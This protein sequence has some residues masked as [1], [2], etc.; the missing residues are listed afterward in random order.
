MDKYIYKNNMFYMRINEMYIYVANQ[1]VIVE[2]QEMY[3]RYTH[4][5]NPMSDYGHAM[6][7]ANRGRVEGG[8]YGEYEHHYDGTDGVRI[9]DLYD[10]IREAWADEATRP[11][12]A[13]YASLTAEQVCACFT[14]EDIVDG[15]DGFDS[16][17][18]LTW[19][20]EQVCEPEGIMALLT[21]DGAI[22]F[23]RALIETQEV[24]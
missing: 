3:Y 6:F 22:V 20:W 8:T 15:A 9:E 18:M 14:P 7:A 10:L 23:D 21:P 4:S 24:E 11:A 2:M 19:L 1:C 12:D 16:G 5:K 17:E 13:Y